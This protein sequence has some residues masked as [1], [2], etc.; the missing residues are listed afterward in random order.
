MGEKF[1]TVFPQLRAIMEKLWSL[2][3]ESLIMVCLESKIEESSMK[4]L[5]TI[6]ISNGKN[7]CMMKNG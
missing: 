3:E 7:S 1:K 4:N 6:L 5:K 2:N